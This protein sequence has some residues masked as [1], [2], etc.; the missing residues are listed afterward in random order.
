MPPPWLV[1]FRR[2]DINAIA[3]RCIQPSGRSKIVQPLEP[4]K[5]IAI[6]VE[7]GSRVSAGDVLLGARRQR[8]GRLR[9]ARARSRS[10]N[11]GGSTPPPGHC[12]G[13]ENGFAP[14]AFVYPP[15]TSDAVRR[16]EERVL[17]ADLEQ[18]PSTQ[19]ADMRDRALLIDSLQLHQTH[20]TT[21]VGER[22][23][24]AQAPASLVKLER[25][26]GKPSRCS[27]PTRCR[28]LPTPNAGR[29]VCGRS[30][31]RHNPGASP[32]SGGTISGTVQQ[33]ARHD[34][35]TG[36]GVRT[37]PHDH[38]VAG[39]PIEIEVMIQNK[40]IGFVEPGQAAV[41]KVESFPFTRYGTID[42]TVLKVS[43]DAVDERGADALSD[44]ET[45]AK[46]QV[47]ATA[48]A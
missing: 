37:A 19:R 41:V 7:N 11:S 44:S 3:Y 31:S 18:L 14:Q 22:G 47:S 23:Q 1:L 29:T 45:A 32:A 30:W 6:A 48:R 38:R 24:L 17:V 5:V 9:G 42:G 2:L 4:G 12:L 36:G 27:L 13:R 39:R 35:R 8:D 20:V 33:V 10:D 43:R 34:D 16:R 28:S 46:P 40:D 26:S 21:L 25:K 15:G